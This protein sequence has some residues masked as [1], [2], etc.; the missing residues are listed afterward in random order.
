MESMLTAVNR[1]FSEDDTAL[2]DQAEIAFFPHI[3]GG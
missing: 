3:S 2:P 1:I